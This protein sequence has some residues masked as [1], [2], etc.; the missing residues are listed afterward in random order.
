M[1]PNRLLAAVLL[2]GTLLV[3][4]AADGAAK[5]LTMKVAD[6]HAKKAAKSVA[7]TFV[8]EGV[9]VEEYTLDRCER[10]TRRRADCEVLYVLTDG[11]ECDDT[12]HVRL[13]T[14]GRVA[15]THDSGT[16]RNR[17]FDDCTEPEDADD[18]AEGEG[19]GEDEEFLDDAD[20][21]DLPADD[22][23]VVGEEEFGDLY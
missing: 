18:L 1:R 19:E 6:K 7:K 16:A 23:E 20:L 12:I 10:D 2:S 21:G 14:R 11:S 15:V 17:A 9:R 3:P 4:A 5:R 8:D 22:G 13:G